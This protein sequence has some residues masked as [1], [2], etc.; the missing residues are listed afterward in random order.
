MDNE[1]LLSCISKPKF[2]FESIYLLKDSPE[3]MA[4]DEKPSFHTFHKKP[5]VMIL[6]MHL[7]I[8]TEKMSLDQN[9]A[10]MSLSNI[11]RRYRH[12]RC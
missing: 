11:H 9:S 4:L 12:M 6:M 10:E 1:Q 3:N 8:Q 5:S 7:N 2:L